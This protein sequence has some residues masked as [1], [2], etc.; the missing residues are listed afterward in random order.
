M[1]VFVSS[2]IRGFEPYR[3]AAVRAAQMLGHEVIRA[4]DFGASPDSPQQVCLAGVRAADVVVL[5]L[6]ERYGWRD[7]DSGLAPTHEEYREARERHPVLVFI[8]GSVTPEAAQRTFIE[9]VQSWGSGHYTQ[10]FASPEALQA[11]AIRA[12][13]DFEL[14][15]AAGSVDEGE[16]LARATALVPTGRQGHEARLC[17]AVAGGPRQQVLRPAELEDTALG[18][19]IMREGLFGA[20]AIFDTGEGTAPELSGAALV[21]AQ[22]HASVLL[23]EAGSVRVVQPTARGRRRG[24]ADPQA[25]SLHP[26][27][28]IEG[29]IR[30]QLERGLR[31]A[32]WLLDHVDPARRLSDIVVVAALLGAGHL[33]WR[34]RAEQEANPNSWPMGRGGDQVVVHPSPA[35][36]NRAALL[37]DTARL[38]ED[39]TVLLRREVRS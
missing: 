26:A 14:S 35:R 30:D 18:R 22:E 21:V 38:A 19:T 4:E 37:H 3:D 32:G 36:R 27:I 9:E 20:A 17:L 12:L 33:G 7:P 15:R 25:F 28:L 1:K 8:Q 31:F 11:A 5:L 24:E 2:V 6:S 10:R 29:D 16:M 39:L 34:T 13:H 23:D